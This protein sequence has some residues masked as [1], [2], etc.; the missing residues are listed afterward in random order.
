MATT[1]VTQPLHEGGDEKTALNSLHSLFP[2]TRE[3]LRR[4]GPQASECGRV[5]IAILNRA[6]RPT[7]TKWHGRSLAGAFTEET[8]KAEFRRDLEELQKHLF[9]Y[10][11]QLA[12]IAGIPTTDFQN[13]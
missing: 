6:V 12:K 7:T 8:Q 10:V 2:T 4:H 13:R 1:I 3:V 11:E 5:A 9:N